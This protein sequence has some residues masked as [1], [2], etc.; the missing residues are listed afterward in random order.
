MGGNP[1]VSETLT[2]DY[3]NRLRSST[4]GSKSFGYDEIGNLT[5]KTGV[6]SYVYGAVGCT[7]TSK[8][9]AVTSTSTGCAN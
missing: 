5:S 1:T 6:G 3:L 4:L 7:A 9:H 8:P 2:Y